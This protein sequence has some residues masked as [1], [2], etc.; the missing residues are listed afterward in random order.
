VVHR[1]LTAL[2]RHAL[3]VSD[4]AGRL[5][6][7]LS[8]WPESKTLHSGALTSP[9]P[10]VR[11]LGPPLAVPARTMRADA[12]LNSHVVAALARQTLAHN[13]DG[14]TSGR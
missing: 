14:A 1:K 4:V 8:G 12:E 2:I 6:N 7:C 9:R 10:I 5:C 11:D 13:P 3:P